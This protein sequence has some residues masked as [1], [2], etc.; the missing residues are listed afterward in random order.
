LAD[1]VN[2]HLDFFFIEMNR[3]ATID[4]KSYSRKRMAQAIERAM[5]A[6]SA[7]EQEKAKRWAAAWGLLGG[8]RSPG[9]HLRRTVLVDRRLNRR[10]QDGS[11]SNPVPESADAFQAQRH[12]Y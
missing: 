3:R 10:E 7:A 8:I 9:V 2:P 6:D 12:P 4:R 1:T 11:A 5:A